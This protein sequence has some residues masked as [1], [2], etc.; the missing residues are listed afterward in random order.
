MDVLTGC[1]AGNPFGVACLR[2]NLAIERHAG[3]QGDKWTLGA[4]P[5]AVRA[6][7]SFRLMSTYADCD[8]QSGP[9]QLCNAP[10]S[11]L[12]IRIDHGDHDL[13][14]T[15]SNDGRNTRRRAFI[16]MAAGFERHVERR[17]FGPA[18]GLLQGKNL[19][20][21]SP[22]DVMVSLADDSAIGD[23]QRSD[24]GIRT[25]FAAPFLG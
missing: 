9:S 6:I 10:A 5:M 25:G 22:C 12:W 4:R 13:S 21:R 24:H 1:P 3:F 23:D 19:G 7:Q 8:R 2:R 14:D 11:Y 16:Q 18:A 20:V 17:V 15:G